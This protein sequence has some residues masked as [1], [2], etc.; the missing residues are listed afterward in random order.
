LRK[1]GST[2]HRR[3][4][5]QSRRRPHVVIDLRRSL[6]FAKLSPFRCP[7]SA[8]RERES[9]HTGIKELDL[10]CAFDDRSRLPD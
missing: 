6:I 4:A 9:L 1:S 5:A 2:A 8:K 10:Q 7:A 3:H